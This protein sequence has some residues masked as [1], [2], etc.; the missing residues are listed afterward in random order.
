MKTVIKGILLI[1]L[2]TIGCIALT[3]YALAAYQNYTMLDAQW[4]KQN[5]CIA[6]YIQMG[7]ERADITREG[8]TCSIVTHH[9]DPKNH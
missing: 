3:L 8:D 7:I 2:V 5:E 1:L 4:D 6:N 9:S